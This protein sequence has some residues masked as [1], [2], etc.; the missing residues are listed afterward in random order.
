MVLYC[1]VMCV[2]VCDITSVV[3]W[4]DK[5]LRTSLKAF[6]RPADVFRQS[7]ETDL[8]MLCLRHNG[9]TNLLLCATSNTKKS[10][11][12]NPL[13]CTAAVYLRDLDDSSG[14]ATTVD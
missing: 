13:L 1:T 3:K 4:L 14:S 12:D 6:R 11:A 8:S 9:V 7:K 5:L 2:C 10:A